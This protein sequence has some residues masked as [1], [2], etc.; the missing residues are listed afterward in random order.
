M[1][2]NTYMEVVPMSNFFLPF[3]FWVLFGH[4]WRDE[5]SVKISQRNFSSPIA[6]GDDAMYWI[7]KKP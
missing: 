6:M 4:D 3:Y 5:I 2:E 7:P 1:K